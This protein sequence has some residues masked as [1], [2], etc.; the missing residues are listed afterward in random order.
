[1]YIKFQLQIS[2]YV[3]LSPFLKDILLPKTSDDDKS[4]STGGNV[5]E[6]GGLQLVVQLLT[7]VH[8]TVHGRVQQEDEAEDEDEGN[9]KVGI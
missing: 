4:V 6:D 7:L 1:M 2:Y 5:V 9:G 8:P 3:V